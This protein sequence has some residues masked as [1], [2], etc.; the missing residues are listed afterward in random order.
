MFTVRKEQQRPKTSLLLLLPIL[1]FLFIACLPLLYILLRAQEVGFKNALS[2]IFRDRVYELLRHT[3]LLDFTVTGAS[4]II[5]VTTAWCIERTNLWGKRM[6]NVLITI[7]FAVP[8]FISSYSW[9]SLSPMF[10]G[11]FG[12]FLVLTLYSYP[13]VH[14]PVAASLRGMNGSLEEVSHSLGYGRWQTF[15][16]VIFPQLRPALFGGALL[17][18]LHTLAEFGALSLLRYDTF[19]TAIFDQYTMAF[20]GASAAMLTT[21]LLFLC[22]I[23]ISLEL[24]SRGKARYVSV[25]SGVARPQKPQSLGVFTPFALLGFALLTVLAVGIPLGRLVYWLLRGSSAQFPLTELLTNLGTTLAYGLGGALATLLIALPLVM[26]SIRARGTLSLL[27]ER[28]PYFIHSLPGLVIGLT[29]VFFAVRY[30]PVLYQTSIVLII[31]YVLLYVPLAQSSVRASYEQAPKRIEEVARS[32]GKG[33]L[34]V[35]FTVTLPL[36]IPG[37]GAGMALVTLKVMTELTATLLLRPTGVD[38]LAIQVWQHTAN[39]EFAAAAPYA[40]LLILISSVPVY[41][42]TMRSFSSKRRGNL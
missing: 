5:G 42:L 1:L 24:Y 27:L 21:V 18:A 29:L 9:V 15:W 34:A 36:I 7:P 30:V 25:G 10:E 4:M 3:L 31:A 13:L 16:R 12:A 22:L 33:P 41:V 40:A 19:T 11:F 23:F 2:L 32:L 6:W 38:T 17:I 8:A 14:L 39:S 26:L 28:V 35:F 20:N 37:I